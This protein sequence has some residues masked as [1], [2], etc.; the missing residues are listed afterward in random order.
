MNSLR[1]VAVLLSCLYVHL[2]IGQS[3]PFQVPIC[4]T[5]S[6]VTTQTFVTGNVFTKEG[7]QSSPVITKINVKGTNISASTNHAGVYKLN[8]TNLVSSKEKITL[9]CKA[10]GYSPKEITIDNPSSQSNII[11]FDLTDKRTIK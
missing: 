4:K 10:A 6:I 9:V 3:K 2:A 11:D 5:G 1:I 8:I 7:G